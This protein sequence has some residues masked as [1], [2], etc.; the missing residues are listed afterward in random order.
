MKIAI[1]LVYV[2]FFPSPFAGAWIEIVIVLV[3]KIA[4]K[5]APLRERGLKIPLGNQYFLSVHLSLPLRERGLKYNKERYDAG[6]R[7]SP[8]FAGA[9]IEISRDYR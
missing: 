8:P 2:T 3:G 1:G 7:L 6:K 5:V 4:D 9:W